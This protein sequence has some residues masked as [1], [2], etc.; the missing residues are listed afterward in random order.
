MDATSSTPST[1]RAAEPATESSAFTEDWCTEHFDHLE[2]E[3]GRRYHETMAYMRTRCPVAHSDRHGGFWVV[4]DYAHVIG[5]LQDWRTFCNGEGVAIPR[6]TFELPVLPDESDPPAHT[7][8]KRLINAYL[9]PAMVAPYEAP[10]RLLV[11][12][13]IDDF[14]EAGRCEFMAAFAGQL[15]RLSFFDLVL[16]APVDDIAQLNEWT[17]TITRLPR[18]PG[19]ETAQ[20]GVRAWI[21]QLV[22]QRAS[23]PRGDIV[24]AVIDADIGGRP[25]TRDEALGTIMQ[26]MFGGFET[27]ASAL[28]HVMI[29]LARDTDIAAR[30]RREPELI[31]DAVEEF[32]RLDPPV[33]CMARTATRDTEL[34]AN[35]IADGDKVLFSIAAA[36]RDEREFD[37]ADVFDLDRASNRHLAFGAGPH[38][39]A[40]SNIARLNMRIA[41]EELVARLHD[42]R[43]EDGAEPLRYHTSFTRS[44]VAVPI[45]FTP[46]PRV[47]A[48]AQG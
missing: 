6:M 15:P 3:L 12:R 43:I 39:C 9:T 27:T 25:I 16:H 4:S 45:T 20:A 41:T 36:N 23:E 24:D 17:L 11:T 35:H 5:V 47:L 31:P 10:T 8:F 1:D 18:Q 48:P 19:F 40:G 30:L 46:G 33:A 29:R 42:I 37:D 34:D 26:L 38:R 14:V 13:L 44:P 32:L 28:G 22:E 7:F 21:E 2:P